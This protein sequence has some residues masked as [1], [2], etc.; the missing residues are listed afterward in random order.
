VLPQLLIVILLLLAMFFLPAG[1]FVYCKAWVYL[2]VLLVPMQMVI[3][4]FYREAPELLERRIRLKE[5][6]TE[7][8]LFIKNS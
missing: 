3:T 4:S 8:S 6:K 1:T 7:Q 5:K 2:V